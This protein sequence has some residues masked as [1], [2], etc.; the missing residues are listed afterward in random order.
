M[1]SAAPAPLTVPSSAPVPLS[2]PSLLPLPGAGGAPSPQAAPTQA[3][4]QPAAQQQ[5]APVPVPQAPRT[6]L[7]GFLLHNEGDKEW[8]TR[9]CILNNGIFEGYKDYYAT[10]EVWNV[11]DLF[12]CSRS[13]DSHGKF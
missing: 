8:S 7:R 3:P 11:L 2:A 9:Y 4:A 6:Q 13:L 10:P 1:A 5:Q 12:H